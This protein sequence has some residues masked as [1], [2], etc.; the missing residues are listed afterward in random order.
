[1]YSKNRILS[2]IWKL[3]IVLVAAWGV[4]LNSGIP[5]GEF[6]GTTFLYYTIQSNILVLVYFIYAAFKCA[7]AIRV[8][9]AKGGIAYSPAV[10]GAVTMGIMVTLLIYWFVLV[11]ADFAMVPNGTAASN[12]TVHLIVPLMAFA[13]WVFFDKKG[14]I[15][16]LDPIRWL[17]LP[18]YYLVFANVAA[19][20]GATYREGARYPYFF[21][22]PD[23]I[24]W[25]DVALNI[26]FIGV[27]FLVLGY[28]VFGIDYLLG[29]LVAMRA[30]RFGSKSG[31][32]Q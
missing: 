22:N 14:S 28:V 8:S 18:L 23:L 12:L 27:A 26:V 9:G 29:R 19:P 24:G 7:R 16:A 32:L 13:D 2:L 11:G 4:Y 21:I 30:E 10:K 3:A 17:V 6:R 20:L 1:M 5:Q 15:R 25:T 31:S